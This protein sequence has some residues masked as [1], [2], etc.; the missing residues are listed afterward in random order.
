MSV[1]TNNGI[2]PISKFL[3]MLP[4]LVL[5]GS[6]PC[7]FLITPLLDLGG[8]LGHFKGCS[9]DM[10]ES[11]IQT[12][13]H[14]LELH[15]FLP[16]D[17]PVIFS[18]VKFAPT[19]SK[20]FGGGY[21]AYHCY[22][23][24]DTK[25]AQIYSAV[26]PN[27]FLFMVPPSHK[28]TCVIQIF[29][30]PKPCLIWID[31]FK[32]SFA[33]YL[34]ARVPLCHSQPNAILDTVFDH[35][36]RYPSIERFGLNPTGKFRWYM[37][38]IRRKVAANKMNCFDVLC[39][40]LYKME[41]EVCSGMH[42]ITTFPTLLS[43][44][45][46]ENVPSYNFELR[47]VNLNTMFNSLH[48]TVQEKCIKA[49]TQDKQY[50]YNYPHK[51][52]IICISSNFKSSLGYSGSTKLI[53][54]G[55][56]STVQETGLDN[57]V[58]LIGKFTDFGQDTE[59]FH[60]SMDEAKIFGP[61]YY[62]R[63]SE[64]M[65]WV[66]NLF[67]NATVIHGSSI[68]TVF[69]STFPSLDFNHIPYLQQTL[70]WYGDNPIKYL[71]CA[72]S[73]EFELVSAIGYLSAFDGYTWMYIAIMGTVTS[74]FLGKTVRL[75]SVYK[76]GNFLYSLIVSQNPEHAGMSKW[77]LG[78][79]LL[80][81]IILSYGYQGNNIRE[82]IKPLRDKPLN[83]W[84]DIVREKYII[85]DSVEESYIEQLEYYLK[86]HIEDVVKGNIYEETE[87]IKPEDL[88]ARTTK[89][90]FYMFM[91]K[92]L[93]NLTNVEEELSKLIL[94]PKTI[95]DALE[96]TYS[97]HQYFSRMLSTC[98]KHAYVDHVDALMKL[99]ANIVTNDINQARNLPLHFNTAP[100]RMNYVS[101]SLE[102]KAVSSKLLIQRIQSISQSGIVTFWRSW[103]HRVEQQKAKILIEM[104]AWIETQPKQISLGHNARVVFYVL[105]L[106]AL[107]SF[108]V[109]LCEI[110]GR[111]L[112]NLQ[113]A[114]RKF[115]CYL[116]RTV[117]HLSFHIKLIRDE[118]RNIKVRRIFRVFADS[119]RLK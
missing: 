25:E 90:S 117:N 71:S 17:E 37:V 30:D 3:K 101:V 89:I 16:F 34:Y 54:L 100:L 67:P 40:I 57:I 52:D 64:K 44:E 18:Q 108:I 70:L 92:F 85:L 98:V 6:I 12:L 69:F 2:K 65:L 13:N 82:L 58:I 46:D 22:L 76:I 116:R 48:K 55:N 35:R 23:N 103:R 75:R 29:I 72:Q 60:V 119:T 79:W 36:M 118:L 80:I 8:F 113:N 20:R 66:E 88:F 99:F 115:S 93:S 61:K 9:I 56:I 87:M 32:P 51:N 97:P 95:K 104:R 110:S 41:S 78:P 114:L 27:P 42:S 77:I 81:G 5:L 33:E 91:M 111:Y 112:S 63:V 62:G 43:L 7:V 38:Q 31:H 15:S 10:R 47:L 28:S 102:H 86:L 19:T 107:V 96:M 24:L 84:E 106:L 83:A 11:V 26:N 68:N 39:N 14:T 94:Y 49:S 105:G 53:P 45:L 59:G 74:V 21:S 4:F 73:R 50:Y 109:C 1:S